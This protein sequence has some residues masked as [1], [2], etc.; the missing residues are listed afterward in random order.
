MLDEISVVQ[1]IKRK[2]GSSGGEVRIDLQNGRSFKATVTYDGI[3]VDDLGSQP[4]L[5]WAVFVE[6]VELLRRNGGRAERGDAIDSK[7]GDPG[8]SL[9]SVEGH[10]AHVVYNKKPGDSIFRRVSQIAAILVWAGVC[11][12]APGELILRGR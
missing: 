10:I 8:L 4:L 5:P 9:G 2:F 7:L 1:V 6:T 11:D 3:M 12:T